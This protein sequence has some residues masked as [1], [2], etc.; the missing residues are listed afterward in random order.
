MTTGIIPSSMQGKGGKRLNRNNS[1]IK[2]KSLIKINCFPTKNPKT[3]SASPNIPCSSQ[4]GLGLPISARPSRSVGGGRRPPVRVEILGVWG[5]TF[6]IHFWNYNTLQR[7][8]FRYSPSRWQRLTGW[9]VGCPFRARSWT[10]LP[11]STAAEK[12]IF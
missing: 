4:F 7:N 3:K 1:S 12:M 10:C 6:K 2:S 8:P 11:P 9:S 5:R